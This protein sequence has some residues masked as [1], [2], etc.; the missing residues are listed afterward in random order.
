MITTQA[1]ERMKELDELITC[2]PESQYGVFTYFRNNIGDHIQTL[3]LLQHV[4][5]RCFVPRDHLQPN[6][7]L[8]LVA[9]G[10]MT[11]GKFPLKSDFKDVKFVGIHLDPKQRT[12]EVVASLR[13]C[14]VTGCR[15]TVTQRFL[16]K[17]GVPTHL[18]RCATLTFPRYTGKR[19]GIYFVDVFPE[20][21][22]IAR[23]YYPDH[24][25]I[26]HGLPEMK[27]GEV[28]DEIMRAQYKQAYELLMLYRKAEL[29]IT[30]RVHAALPATAFGT[31]VIYVGI[32][33][34]LDDR[35]SILEGTGIKCVERSLR[36]LP[37]WAMK[38]PKP[39]DTRAFRQNYV[40]FL[41]KS[42]SEMGRG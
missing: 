32:S 11:H 15:D 2:S 26:S 16:K 25:S 40:D 23:K 22:A 18:T 8:C 36:Y 9:N 10:W 29:V 37:S 13:Q 39:I 28:T 21:A 42:L 4:T 14:G 34:A 30:T 12:P 1:E 5:P 17:Q 31:P 19:E 41:K 20:I 27:I 24:V 3:A 6:K 7:D 38:K 35:V 33:R